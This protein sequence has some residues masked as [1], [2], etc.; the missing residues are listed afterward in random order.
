[1]IKSRWKERG[2]KKRK[3]EL[4]WS[5]KLKLKCVLSEE[6]IGAKFFITKSQQQEEH[7][8]SITLLLLIFIP[9]ANSRRHSQPPN[10]HHLFPSRRLH[11]SSFSVFNFIFKFSISLSDFVF[12][13]IF[14]E[15]LVDRKRVPS[16]WRKRVAA[17][18]ARIS[19]EFS[20]LPKD[21]HPLFQTLDPEG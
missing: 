9:N 1:M 6:H 12:F 21:S 14:Q 11:S 5:W 15:W 8:T 18:R 17:I 3:V 19:N 7:L 20:S 4:S 10:W 16:D 2:R 13:I